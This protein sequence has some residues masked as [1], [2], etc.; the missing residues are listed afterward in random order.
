MAIFPL[1]N[2]SKYGVVADVDAYALPT[3]AWSMAVNARF[4]DGF[5]ER[6]PI[7]KD[8]VTLANPSPR[9]VTSSEEVG[10]LSS[11]IVGYLSGNVTRVTNGVETDISISGYTPNN[12]DSV[13][14]SCTLGGVL[15]INRNDRIPWSIRPSETQFQPLAN[16]DS[17]WRANVLRSAGSALCAFGITKNGVSY[18]TMIKTSEFATADSV[19]STWDETD[20]TNNATENIL[21]E[22]QS[23]ITDAQTMGEVMIVYGLNETWLME[24]DGSKNVWAYHKLFDTHGAINANC[25]V[26]ID[27]KHYVFGS[28]DIWRHD[29]IT[30]ESICDGRVKR[31][32]FNSLSMDKANRCFVSYNPTLNEVGFYYCSVDAYVGFSPVDGCNRCAIYNISANNWTFYDMPYVYGAAMANATHADTW[33]QLSTWAT[34]GGTWLDE[35]ESSKR[36]LIIVGDD[37]TAA[38]LTRTLYVFDQAGSSEYSSLPV[39]TNAT[40]PAKLIRDG[41]DLD[42]VGADLR[43]Y[44]LCSSIYPQGRL[45]PDA[46]P[47]EFSAGSADYFNQP[48]TMSPSQTYDGNTLYKLD[49]NAS[50]R[51]LYLEIVHNDFHYFKLTGM[52]LDL[53]VLGER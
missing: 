52:D 28:S 22:M 31:F 17:T 7:F 36:V 41:I 32:L 13:F 33:E 37:D 30:P 47:L 3:E 14:T 43:G 2:L 26:E 6:G 23:A 18:P 48:V 38:A 50:G 16:W 21:A 40:K 39:D 24:A 53:D 20:P 9:Y 10:G 34:L 46:A 8:Y 42:E 25:S 29:G 44:K 15:Y 11:V 35:Q 4:Q 27:K 19:P 45:D 1:R 5:I 12:S 51:Y 49:F